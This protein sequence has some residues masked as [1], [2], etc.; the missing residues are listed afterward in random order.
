MKDNKKARAMLFNI[1]VVPLLIDGQDDSSVSLSLAAEGDDIKI[2]E[3]KPNTD[4]LS[5]QQKRALNILN[6]MYSRYGK[7]TKIEGEKSRA[8]RVEIADFQEECLTTECYKMKHHF[9]RAVEKLVERDLVRFCANMHFIYPL[10]I[11]L[12]YKDKDLL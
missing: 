1:H 10:P 6:S 9:R 5:P 7:R 11:Y 4:K 12:E 2:S 8:P 3:E